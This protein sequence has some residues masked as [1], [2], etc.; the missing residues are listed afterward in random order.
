MPSGGAADRDV[1]G[2]IP[3]GGHA[4]R[5]SPLPCSKELYP[6]GL[7]TPEGPSA[8]RVAAQYLIDKMREAS[9]RRVF[10]VLRQGK[11]DI[12]AYF[13]DGSASGLHIGYLM[14]GAP[15]GVP[16]TLNQASPFVQDATVAFGFPDI[17]FDSVN[18]FS[19]L[20]RRQSESG[21]D[22]TLGLLPA[23]HARSREDRVQL[24]GGGTVARIFLNPPESSLEYSWAIAV[25]KPSFTRF[26]REYVE[27]RLSTGGQ[28]T[29]L[30]VGHSFQTGLEAGLQV[31]G[32]IVGNAPYVDIGTPAG[33]QKAIRHALDT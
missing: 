32:V 13:G 27:T 14:L 23:T 10:I 1:V 7:P 8:P 6:V 25:W 2:L 20:L 29:E 24:D 26:L 33:L 4:S 12:P 11:W 31:D 16:F 9:I 30:S 15:F 18:P 3:A 19:V 28:G 21:A 17:L 5:I 22:V